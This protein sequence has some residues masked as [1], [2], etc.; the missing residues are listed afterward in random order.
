[1]KENDSG[2]SLPCRGQQHTNR[3]CVQKAPRTTSCHSWASR[4][5]E[6]ADIEHP[7]ARSIESPLNAP[8]RDGCDIRMPAMLLSSSMRR[9]TSTRIASTGVA[10]ERSPGAGNEVEDETPLVAT[11]PLLAEPKPD[12][13]RQD[14]CSPTEALISWAHSTRLGIQ[15]RSNGRLHLGEVDTRFYSS[16][17]YCPS[18]HLGWLG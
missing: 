15:Y 8:R 1:M 10:H 16:L 17:R 2:G 3:A 12:E 13:P 6:V 9:S 14:G 11:L 5:S 4:S 7:L 18:F